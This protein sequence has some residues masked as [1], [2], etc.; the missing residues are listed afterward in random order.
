M[1][2]YLDLSVITAMEIDGYL[3]GI[4]DTSFAT[5]SASALSRGPRLER[6]VDLPEWRSPQDNVG[7][8]T[9]SK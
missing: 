8:M 4:T 5:A 3:R 2:A 1:A 6:G 9:A 7:E